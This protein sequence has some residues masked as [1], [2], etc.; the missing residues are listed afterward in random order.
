MARKIWH[1]L[2]GQHWTMLK[3]QENMFVLEL[4]NY[5]T[6]TKKFDRDDL[7][8][9]MTILRCGSN[10]EEVKKQIPGVKFNRVLNAY[11]YLKNK[12]EESIE[13]WQEIKE[14]PDL[15]TL[16]ANAKTAAKLLPIP[17]HYALS[18]QSQHLETAVIDSIAYSSGKISAVT[19]NA[20]AVEKKLENLKPGSIEGIELGRKLFDPYSPGIYASPYYKPDRVSSLTPLKVKELTSELKMAFE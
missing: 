10:I 9:L 1:T 17:I 19:V 16:H 12:L 14:N 8:L 6:K 7:T 15:A 3:H 13:S 11:N 4:Q 2:P 20:H 5:A 18:A